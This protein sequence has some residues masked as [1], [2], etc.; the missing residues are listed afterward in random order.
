MVWKREVQRQ[1]CVYGR[2]GGPVG[3]V[4]AMVQWQGAEEKLLLLEA[5]RAGTK[6]GNIILI[7]VR[8][9]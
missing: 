2:N 5:E 8:W 9:Q 1:H 4:S 3:G 6:W 7:E